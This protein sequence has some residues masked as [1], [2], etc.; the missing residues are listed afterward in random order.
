M[1]INMYSV[2]RRKTKKLCK[3]D[4]LPHEHNRKQLKYELLMMPYGI[5]EVE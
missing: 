5:M 4:D 3:R 1:Y 2:L